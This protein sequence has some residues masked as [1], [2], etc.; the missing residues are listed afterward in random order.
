M[1]VKKSELYSSIWSAC[2]QLRGGMDASQYKDYVLALLFVK[3]VSDKY[4][5][6]PYAPIKIPEGGSFADMQAAKGKTDIGERLNT[7]I[8]ALA[9][10]NNLTGTID[11]A[12][13]DDKSKLGDGSEMQVT[14][15]KLVAIF[16]D[17]ALD[18]SKNR[19]QD[20][21]LLG[22][23]YEYLMRNFATQS[24]K[25]KGQFY[26]P[27]EVSRVMAKIIGIQSATSSEQTIY[28]PTC[29]S[30]SLLLKAA[31]EAPVDV[32]IYGQENDVA[33]R[34]LAKM[35]M[36]LHDNT[37]ARVE[38]G[39]TITNPLFREHGRL[40][41]FDFAVANPPFSSK[42]WGNG[43]KPEEDEFDRFVDG[44]PPTKNGDYA[45]FQHLLRSLKSTGKGAII[46]PHGVLFRGN[47]EATIRESIVRRGYIKGIVGLPA[48]LFYGTGIP[49]CIIVVDK[50]NAEARRGIFMIDA[51]KG[52]I[53]DGNKNRLRHQDIHK[54]VD[55]FN[56]QIELPCYSRMV[57]FEEIERNEYNLNIPRYIDTTEAED[58]QDIEA[59]LLGGIPE[60]DIKELE[61]Y[62][63]VFPAVADELFQTNG[64]AG[65]LDLNVEAPAIKPTIFQH[66]EFVQYADSVNDVFIDWVQQNI[67]YLKAIEPGDKPKEIIHTISEDLL[68][69]FEPVA[70]IDKYDVYQSLMTYWTDVMQ[71]DVYMLV[72]EGWLDANKIPEML[73][74]LDMI[75]DLEQRDLELNATLTELDEQYGGKGLLLAPAKHGKR[76][77]K[78]KVENLF[79][80]AKQT[81]FS[82]DDL[83]IVTR[84]HDA[85]TEL[86]RNLE[87]INIAREK[88]ADLLEESMIPLEV[89]IN[90]YFPAEQEAIIDLEAQSEAITGEMDELDQEHGAEGGLLYE[91]KSDAGKLG[92]GSA[93]ARLK[94][95][96]DAPDDDEEVKEV[97]MIQKWLGLNEQKSNLDSD[98][99]VARADLDEKVLRK[100]P[101]LSEDEVKVLVVED[102]WLAQVE[103]DIHS[104][105]DRVSQRLTG[106]IKQLADRYATPL[107]ELQVH[108]EAQRQKVETHLKRMGYT[109]NE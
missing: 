93:E 60:R 1:A 45:F 32:T 70:L 107:P 31:D 30:G 69:R 37:T 8:K 40:Q 18:F 12:D 65:Y 35:N 85:F 89:L 23:A 34:A 36:I 14:L 21:D 56:N 79:K 28:D 39:N 71:D 99:K 74:Y 100:Y 22:D 59:H 26:T 75:E 10:E 88:M 97:E 91:A 29:G 7:V 62:W 96:G 90:R 42:A 55:V 50:E 78:K 64:R 19:A 5:G 72:S 95:L 101:T 43:I 16:E 73:E 87:Q 77:T 103:A 80:K 17:P 82:D 2:D 92:K 24:G 9:K 54:I 41:L 15:T 84:C 61:P 47:V 63:K 67:D 20:D 104:E 76:F 102:K 105:L 53:K 52:F 94:E 106:R 68:V 108:A 49:A 44:V 38:R 27:A 33:T 57:G 11:T 81:P 109:W 48:N 51:S 13:F 4:A 6:Q 46:L 86:E 66:P 83:A 3:Y 98:V 58:I 25:S